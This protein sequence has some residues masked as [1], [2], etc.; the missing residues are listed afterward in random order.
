LAKGVLSHLR[1][2]EVTKVVEELSNASAG[3]K[4]YMTKYQEGLSVVWDRLLEEE[5]LQMCDQAKEW[6][7]REPPDEVKQQ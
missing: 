7:E 5:Q 1:K 3:S 4:E 2:A 6:T